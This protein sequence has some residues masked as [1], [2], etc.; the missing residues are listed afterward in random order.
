MP[1]E[2][3]QDRSGIIPYPASPRPSDLPLDAEY[4]VKADTYNAN[5]RMIAEEVGCPYFTGKHYKC[6]EGSAY[7]GSSTSAHCRLTLPLDY[8]EIGDVLF[9]GDGSRIW[10]VVI[11]QLDQV[12]F[13]DSDLVHGT[14]GTA[15]YD[16]IKDNLEFMVRAKSKISKVVTKNEIVTGNFADGLHGDD[17]PVSQGSGDSIK[18]QLDDIYVEHESDGT[19]SA[20]IIG[21]AELDKDDVLKTQ[22]FVNRVRNGAF[23]INNAASKDYWTDIGTPNSAVNSNGKDVYPQFDLECTTNALTEGVYQL[24]LEGFEPNV[25]IRLCFVAWGDSGGEAIKAQMYTGIESETEEI[26]LTTSKTTYYLTLTPTDITTLIVRFISN[27]ASTITWHIALVTIALGDVHTR[28]ERSSQDV[29]FDAIHTTDFYIPSLLT[30][31]ADVTYVQWT[32]QRTIQLVRIDVYTNTKPDVDVTVR[33]TDGSNNVD[34]VISSSTGKGSNSSTTQQFNKGTELTLKVIDNAATAGT[35][36][37]YI[38][39]YRMV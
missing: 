30:S 15:N 20:G 22:A 4:A 13:S 39:Q 26:T 35:L 33:I 8:T 27:T 37:N 31:G 25:P 29:L 12:E 2:T 32:P 24:L 18:D 28:P 23:N 38:L 3:G 16:T 5:L 34:V 36:V 17:I 14:A 9:I 6:Y 21:N 1:V 7:Y 11:A 10:R 19:H